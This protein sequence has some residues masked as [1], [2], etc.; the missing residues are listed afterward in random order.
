MTSTEKYET[1]AAKIV[2]A[3]LDIH[4]G[5][6]SPDPISKLAFR[7]IVEMVAKLLKD[8]DEHSA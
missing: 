6:D 8:C 1:V 3:N 7:N 5:D 2:R 4:F